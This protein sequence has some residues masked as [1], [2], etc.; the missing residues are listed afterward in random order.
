MSAKLCYESWCSHKILKNNA[1]P[2]LRS[3]FIDEVKS[4]HGIDPMRQTKEGS[5]VVS[6]S[7]EDD[8]GVPY[9]MY[10]SRRSNYYVL[11]AR[12][13]HMW[14]YHTPGT[15]LILVP[16][17]RFN[18]AK[19]MKTFHTDFY[20]SQQAFRVYQR[21]WNDAYQMYQCGMLS[22]GV[23]EHLE[24]YVPPNSQHNPYDR[25]TMRHQQQYD[26]I[27]RS[28]LMDTLYCSPP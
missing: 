12:H 11:W 8:I 27:S 20:A 23:Q 9:H 16:S 22:C 21:E 14:M 17:E 26:S 24:A 5:M 4:T 18:P 2:L 15:Q 13:L 25:R 19:H 7:F 3:R 10:K 28:N 1:V 6:N